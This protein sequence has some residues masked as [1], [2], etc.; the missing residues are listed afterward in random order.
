MGGLGPRGARLRIDRDRNSTLPLAAVENVAVL[1]GE[2]R[3]V[4]APAHVE[5]RAHAGSPLT[6]EDGAR[7]Y[8]FAAEALD[9]EPLRRRIAPVLRAGYA[10]LVRHGSPLATSSRPGCRES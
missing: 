9:P 8:P 3:V 2:E 7:P 5:P 4:L 10:F 1:Q 6:D